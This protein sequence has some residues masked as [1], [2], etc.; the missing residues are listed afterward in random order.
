[1][2]LAGT[3][4][5]SL[6]L[7]CPALGQGGLGQGGVGDLYDGAVIVLPSYEYLVPAASQGGLFAAKDDPAPGEQQTPQPAPSGCPFRDGKLELM[8]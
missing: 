4:A 2:R 6:C 7:V 8:V 3:V 1:M 5:A